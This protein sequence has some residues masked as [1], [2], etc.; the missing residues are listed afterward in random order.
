MTQ[1]TIPATPGAAPSQTVGPFFTE[2]LLRPDACRNVLIQPETSGRRIRIEGR[3][4]DGDGVGVPDAM[5]EL[6]QANNY[7]RYHHPSDRREEAALDPGF[8]GFGR[9]GTDANGAY[10]FETIKPGAVPFG[11]NEE[12]MQ[13]PHICVMV[14]ARGLL[15]HLATRLYFA[16][17]SATA[18]DPILGLV[19]NRASPDADRPT[20]NGGMHRP[21]TDGTSSCKGRARR[22]FSTYEGSVVSDPRDALYTTPAMTETFA[23]RRLMHIRADVRVQRCT[24]RGAEARCDVPSAACLRHRGGPGRDSGN[25]LQ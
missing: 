11:R 13:A 25:P 5:V 1:L 19:L 3:V 21:C 7:G 4:L 14:L 23:C 8:T 17:E 16:D 24:R 10:W 20:G 18:R 22:F 9:S 2:C 6:W 12:R 15:N